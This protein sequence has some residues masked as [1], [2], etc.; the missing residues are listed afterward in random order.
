MGKKGSK[1]KTRWRTLS[2]GANKDQ[3]TIVTEEKARPRSQ[4]KNLAKVI[5]I[6]HRLIEIWKVASL[7]HE[8]LDSG[9]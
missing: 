1:R 2:I 5:L 3:R 6:L 8:Y 4:L 7:L 9:A